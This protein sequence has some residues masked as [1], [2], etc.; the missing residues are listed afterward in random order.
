MVFLARAPHSNGRGNGF[1]E[2]RL[3][4]IAHRTIP[5]FCHVIIHEIDI[6]MAIG[7]NITHKIYS[8]HVSIL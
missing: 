6:P 7:M 1:I 2:I 3:R 8:I 5:S 4:T